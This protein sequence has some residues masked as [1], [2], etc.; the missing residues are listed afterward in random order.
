MSRIA[1]ATSIQVRKS[2]ADWFVSVPGQSPG[3]SKPRSDDGECVV[4]QE[5]H[6]GIRCMASRTISLNDQMAVLLKQISKTSKVLDV[7]ELRNELCPNF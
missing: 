4:Q 2:Q 1:G 5:Q 6:Q 7:K 3:R